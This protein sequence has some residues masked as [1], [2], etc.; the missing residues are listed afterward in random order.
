[1]NYKEQ[2]A[3][4]KDEIIQQFGKENKVILNAKLTMLMKKQRELY[5]HNLSQP[6]VKI[7]DS[8]MFQLQMMDMDY[9]KNSSRSIIE[10]ALKVVY[11]IG[12]EQGALH[13]VRHAMKPVIAFTKDNQIKFDSIREAGILMDCNHANIIRAI[14]NPLTKCKGY[15][16]KY[17]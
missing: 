13:N 5:E 7:L 6:C 4:K 17:A 3:V 15:F 1:M 14:K 9:F 8:L 12:M 2:L 10:E 16:W 11:N